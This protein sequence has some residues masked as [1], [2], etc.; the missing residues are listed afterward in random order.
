M[1]Q[2]NYLVVF[3]AVFAVRSRV[4][5]VVV[6]S[7]VVL[8]MRIPVVVWDRVVCADSIV[9]AVWARVQVVVVRSLMVLL[10]MG[11]LV[12]VIVCADSVGFA[13]QARVQVVVVRSPVVVLLMRIPVVVWDRVV[14]R[15]PVIALSES[16]SVYYPSQ[17][18]LLQHNACD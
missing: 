7:P 6:R 14:V 18:S 11:I 16:G 10:M 3:A 12:M 15:A 8:L 17:F 13:V 4:Q 1:I 5:V 2:R 9:F